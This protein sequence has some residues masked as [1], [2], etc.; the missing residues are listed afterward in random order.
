MSLSIEKFAKNWAYKKKTSFKIEYI[1]KIDQFKDKLVDKNKRIYSPKFSMPEHN[2]QFELVIIIDDLIE[3]NE[4]Y[5]G[6]YVNCLPGS[7][8]FSEIPVK[9]NANIVILSN[10]GNLKMEKSKVIIVIFC[11]ID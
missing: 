11:F 9:V 8:V 10:D 4:K 3:N 5:S 6:L 1:W 2:I 7:S